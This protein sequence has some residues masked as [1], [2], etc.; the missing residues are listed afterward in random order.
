MCIIIAALLPVFTL[1]SV[2]GR[3]FRPLALTY[4]F[5]LVGAL[6]FSLTT[7][8]A[9]CAVLFRPGRAS[10]DEPRWIDRLRQRYRA[11]LELALARRAYP[12][13][14]ACALLVAGGLAASHVGTEFLP[15]L[16]EGDFDVLVEMPAAP[17]TKA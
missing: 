14:A 12:L 4:A 17:I 9:L 15:E 8:P 10:Y 13:V 5:A 1:Q 16:D 2:E 7:V 3:I 6:V 11:L